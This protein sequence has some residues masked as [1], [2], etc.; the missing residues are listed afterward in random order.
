MTG[1][2][3]SNLSFPG[4]PGPTMSAAA[5]LRRPTEA[6]RTDRRGAEAHRSPQH[7]SAPLGCCGIGPA[8]PRAVPRAAAPGCD[9]GRGYGDEWTG[10]AVRRKAR[11]TR[12]WRPSGRQKRE[13][14]LT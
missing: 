11:R 1:T 5:T 8:V 10:W 9:S 6:G 4:P 3:R 12:P 7:P 14:P 2:R 13:A